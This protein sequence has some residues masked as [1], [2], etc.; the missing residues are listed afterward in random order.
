[1]VD[2]AGMMRELR[3]QALRVTALDLELAPTE[4]RPL[5]WGAIM[6]LGYPTGIATLMTLA[7]GTTSLYFSNG[8]GVIGAGEHP[9]V[10]DAAETFLDVVEDH[11][12]EFPR[13]EATPTPRIGRVRFYVRTFDGTLGMEAMEE[14]LGRNLHHLSPVYHA[15]HAVITAIRETSEGQP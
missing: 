15:G 12:T 4:S 10:R 14:D 1:M 2:P 11:V 9:T 7:E 13:V 6:E 8:G 5:V 3:E